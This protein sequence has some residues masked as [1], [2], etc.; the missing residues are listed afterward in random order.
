MSF[1]NTGASNC[2]VISDVIVKLIFVSKHANDGSRN[3]ILIGDVVDST[4]ITD[5]INDT[6]ASKRWYP[7]RQLIS[8]TDEKDDPNTESLDGIDYIVSQGARKFSAMSIK[9]D[10]VYLSKISKGKCGEFAVYGVDKSNRLIGEISTDG[11]YLYPLAIENGTFDAKLVKGTYSTIQKTMISFNYDDSLEDCDL[12]VYQSNTD[13]VYSC[14]LL[15]I[16]AKITDVDKF[17]F[18]TSLTLDYGYSNNPQRV[19]GW[20]LPDFVLYDITNSEILIPES[21][22]ERNG[23]YSF[24]IEYAP[25][26]RLISIAQKNPE[27]N[28]FELFTTL[29]IPADTPVAPILNNAYVID[30]TLN[31]TFDID[32]NISN[33]TGISLTSDS[34]A[35]N[36]TSVLFG[37]GTDTIAFQLNRI[38]LETETITLTINAVSNQIYSAYG[39]IQFEGVTDFAVEAGG[40]LEIFN[41][42]TVFNNLTL[43]R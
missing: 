37:D 1:G 14:G 9:T 22:T 39:A 18:T 40:V 35:L 4:Y 16:N 41:N 8:V 31:L 29:T 3:S 21:M 42:L 5:R 15:D 10:S 27:K 36:V 12:R 25:E 32:V 30:D 33:I 26:S 6:D 43:F 34:G 19:E 2:E 24:V 23:V 7:S 38:P 20:A 11:L 28:G 13:I 17:G